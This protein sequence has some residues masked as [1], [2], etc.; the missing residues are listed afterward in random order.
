MVQYREYT[1]I[2][3]Q[4]SG[5][6]INLARDFELN[7]EMRSG[8]TIWSTWFV[9]TSKYQTQ[10]KNIFQSVLG[11]PR[12]DINVMRKILKGVFQMREA[13]SFIVNN[14]LRRNLSLG[15]R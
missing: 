5:S 7:Q 13:L 3:F 14:F 9:A 15:R 6:Y 1:V 10:A 11:C 12:K 2:S 8:L 4:I